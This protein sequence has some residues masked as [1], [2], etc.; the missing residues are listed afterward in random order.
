M[1]SQSGISAFE[2]M[3]VPVLTVKP[4]VRPRCGRPQAPP[5]AHSHPRNCAPGG[6]ARKRNSRRATKTPGRWLPPLLRK[7]RSTQRNG[8]VPS[9]THS[10]APEYTVRDEL[11]MAKVNEQHSDVDGAVCDAGPLLRVRHQSLR[12]HH[13]PFTIDSRTM[14]RA[15]TTAGSTA[16][17]GFPADVSPP[18][19]IHCQTTKWGRAVF[20]DAAPVRQQ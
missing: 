13:S 20:A 3:A 4:I 6:S 10:E 14:P 9:R 1:L 5:F 17:V 19:P 7:A 2:N 18:G 15:S 11:Q 12:I 8:S 16:L